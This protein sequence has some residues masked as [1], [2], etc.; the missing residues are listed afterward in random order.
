LNCWHVQRGKKGSLRQVRKGVQYTEGCISSARTPSLTRLQSRD[1]AREGVHQQC[2]NNITYTFAVQGLGERG[3]NK[4]V[5]RGGCR[6][7]SF[8]WWARVG[9]V[10]KLVRLPPNTQ[11]P[12]KACELPRSLI[13]HVG[14]CN[15][16][17]KHT[18]LSILSMTILLILFMTILSILPM[19][20]WSMT[21]LSITILSNDDIVYDDIVKR[22]YCHLRIANHSSGVR[23]KVQ[24]CRNIEVGMGILGRAA[25]AHA[26]VP[27]WGHVTLFRKVQITSTFQFCTLPHLDLKTAQGVVLLG[28]Y[29]SIWLRLL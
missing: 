9:K 5:A 3:V 23:R 24:A 27:M 6:T 2:E 20:I 14:P 18:I 26:C 13:A 19:T 25:S 15:P 7:S 29:S 21:I 10:T 22:R 1:W 11:R 4:R 17:Q 16:A 8:M 12:W 28:K